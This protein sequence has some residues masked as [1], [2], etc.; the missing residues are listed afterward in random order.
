MNRLDLTG[1]PLTTAVV[2]HRARSAKEKKRKV[3]PARSPA[4]HPPPRGWD[5]GGRRP[6]IVFRTANPGPALTRRGQVRRRGGP[7]LRRSPRHR[8]PPWRT[9]GGA[10]CFTRLNRLAVPL[11]PGPQLPL[12]V[13]FLPA[14]F[15]RR[16][17]F[18]CLRSNDEFSPVLARL[19]LS[20]AR[21]FAAIPA[22][23]Y[24]HARELGVFGLFGT[25][26][27]PRV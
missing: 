16:R 8:L 12:L 1:A 11:L 18:F 13:C 14:V 20:R 19:E 23:P 6:T 15:D 7:H 21:G 25:L 2:Q 10:R 27:R 22:S 9:G 26:T 24:S 5:A 4:R 3:S 17:V